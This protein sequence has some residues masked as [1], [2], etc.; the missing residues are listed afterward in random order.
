MKTISKTLLASALVAAS[1][2]AQAE[3]SANIAAVSDYLFRGVSQ[4]SNAAVQ[5]GLDFSDESG[6]YAGTWL[7]NVN[8]G[9]QVETDLYAGYSA[10]MNGVGVDVGGLYYWYPDSGGDQ[11]GSELDYAEIY[12]GLSFG[13]FSANVAYTVWGETDNAPFDNGDVY[14]SASADIPLQDGF[15]TTLT[16]GYY[17]F[18]QKISGAG[19]NTSSESYLHWAASLAKDVGDFGSVSVNYEQTD[20]DSND[21]N[22]IAADDGPKIWI[23][24]SKEF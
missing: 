24:W 18:D 4:S 13:V 15:S 2:I 5:G 7:S 14:Y 9:G 11:T 21:G 3:I 23:G 17:D 22:V 19:V 16:V 12:A 20:G 1:G 8:F 10:D 6:L